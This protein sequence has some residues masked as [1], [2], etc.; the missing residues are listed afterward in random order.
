[1]TAMNITRS[2]GETRHSKAI[3]DRVA[4]LGV[5]C[6]GCTNCRGLCKE[7]IEAM[8]VPEVVLKSKRETV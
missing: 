4:R 7:L 8:I 5:P 2:R 1:M 3:A 6:V